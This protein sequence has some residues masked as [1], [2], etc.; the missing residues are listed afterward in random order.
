LSLNQTGILLLEVVSLVWSMSPLGFVAIV[1]IRWL[2]G[3][4]L[5]F[6]FVLEG[7]E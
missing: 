6:Q 4:L 2:L 5:F 7:R 1:T 3:S